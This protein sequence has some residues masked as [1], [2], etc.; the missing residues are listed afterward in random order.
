MD[1]SD[2]S[3]EQWIPRLMNERP[4]KPRETGRQEHTRRA[5]QLDKRSLD[6]YETGTYQR[7]ETAFDKWIKLDHE[8]LNGIRDE[9]WQVSEELGKLFGYD[10]AKYHRG[11][12]TY[13]VR[14]LR[15]LLATHEPRDRILECLR[16]NLEIDM[17]FE[18]Q[19]AW[20]NYC[21]GELTGRSEEH[22]WEEAE[23]AIP[24]FAAVVAGNPK[25]TSGD[26]SLNNIEKIRRW[27]ETQK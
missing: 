20:I 19:E 7:K 23:K 10:T 12:S 6:E 21:S 11:F 24:D 14:D 3:L 1:M 17:R 4:V 25:G 2:V 13:T 16:K 26:G 18:L 27:L 8:K 15:T 22:T 9:L 5:R